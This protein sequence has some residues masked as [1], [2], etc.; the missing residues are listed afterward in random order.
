M[1]IQNTSMTDEMSSYKSI[2][3]NAA[4]HDEIFAIFKQHE[5]YTPVL[6]HMNYNQGVGYK[7]VILQDNILDRN[8]FEKFK[9]NDIYG[10]ATLCDYGTEFGQISP[11][12]LRY[13][14]VLSDLV[15][16]FGSLD[17]FNIVE[18]GV[19]YGGQAK[20]IMDYFNVGSYIFADLPEA[21]ALTKKYLGKF[22]YKNLNFLDFNN[23]PDKKYDLVISNFAI[24]E[25]SREMQET[26]IDKIFN[27]SDRGYMLMNVIRRD[28]I[29]QSEW[30]NILP[31]SKIDVEVPNTANGNYILT[32]KR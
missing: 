13:V 23:L 25:C 18:I 2:C 26:Y 28:N 3:K 20:I 19:G 14:K 16:Y 32:F 4:E 27:N 12:T 11:S 17:N 29:H 5:D 7:N 30:I 21:L 24:S 8:K 10:T 1:I 15:K 6:E 9:E 22:N 31:N